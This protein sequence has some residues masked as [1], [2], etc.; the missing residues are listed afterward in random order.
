MQN[1]KD[2]VFLDR[3]IMSNVKERRQYKR[4]EDVLQNQEVQVQIRLLLVIQGMFAAATALSGTFI[5]VYL[6]K[7]SNDYALIGW[8]SLAS[9][10]SNVV[11]FWLAG[12]WVKEYNKMNSLRVG[13]VVSAA[14]YMFVL[15]LQKQAVDYVLLL[16]TVQGIGS[17]L[18]WLAF[19]VVYFEVTSPETRD[20]FNGFAGL[21]NSGASMLAP[22]I[23]G[24][25][26][27]QMKNTSGYKFIFT[28]SLI[29]FLIG[30]ITSFFLKKRRVEGTYEWFHAM[31]RMKQKRNPWRL[32]VPALMAQGVREGVF[33]FLIG[34]MVFVATNNEMQVGNYFLITSAVALVSYLILGKWLKPERRMAGMLLGSIM[35]IMVILPFFWDVNYTTLLIFGIGTSIFIPLFIIPMT[36]SVFDIIGRDQ[37]SAS[38]RVEYVVLRELGLNIGR[39]SGILLFIAVLSWRKDP[40]VMN[41][42]ILIIGS[43]PIAA[44]YYMNRLNKQASKKAKPLD[45]KA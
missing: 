13:I 40:Q 42:L 4:V 44:W 31:V 28:L 9:Q 18:F 36:S 16:G 6:W 14:F 19:N 33:V 29:I 27:T 21:L 37:E 20:R 30:V 3:W 25:L 26:I 11:T 7:V 24:L 38:H 5:N 23:S 35:L 8:F 45:G 34:L 39:I 32:A 10:V 43:S 12:K 41:W 22:W 1:S 2:Y 17:G 15:L